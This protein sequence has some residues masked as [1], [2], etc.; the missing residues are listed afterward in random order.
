MN[1][2][3]NPHNGTSLTGVIDL[4]AHSI[5]LFQENEPPQNIK[6]MFT[7]KSD[8]SVA[9]PID[10][11]IDELGNNTIQMY[12]FIGFIN[13]EKVGGLE[14]LS[15]YMNESFFSKDAPAINKHHYHITKKQYNE[16]TRNIY[17]VDK[18]KS[19]KTNNRNFNDNNLYNKEIINHKQ[20]NE[21]RNQIK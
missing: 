5:S 4:T 7:P 11:Q 13:D 20:F 12:Q 1:A 3:L 2:F 16:E 14:S 6:D 19:Y 18:S 15:N 21:L 8:I 10:V 17:N 9:E